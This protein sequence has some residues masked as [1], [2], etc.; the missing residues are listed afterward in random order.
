M[1][2]RITSVLLLLLALAEGHERYFARKVTKQPYPVKAQPVKSPGP[3]GP[4]GEPGQ[5][6][7][8]GPPGPPGKGGYGSPGPKGPPGPPG[9]AGYSSAGKPGGCLGLLGALDQLATQLQVNLDHMASLGQWG[10]EGSQA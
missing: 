7:P 3:Q 5:P 4:P 9:P 1:D 6:G 2:L 10:L 8:P